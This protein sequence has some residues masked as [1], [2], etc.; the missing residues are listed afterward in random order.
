[1]LRAEKTAVSKVVWT[2]GRMSSRRKD[3]TCVCRWCWD[4]EPLVVRLCL[5][6]LWVLTESVWMS[7]CFAL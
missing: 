5:Q 4:N 1:M 2:I 6:L 3:L 7:G